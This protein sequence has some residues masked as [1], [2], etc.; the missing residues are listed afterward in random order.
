MNE[1]NLSD[2]WKRS[3]HWEKMTIKQ[4]LITIWFGLSFASLVLASESVL[5]AVV[6]LVNFGASV[7][8][9]SKYVQMEDE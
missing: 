6:V 8:S 4:K 5:L 9:V 1:T 2:L 7:F 3:V